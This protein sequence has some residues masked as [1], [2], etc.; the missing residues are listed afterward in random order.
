MTE[1]NCKHDQWLDELIK[2]YELLKKELKTK[3]KILNKV[4]YKI[5]FNAYSFL[6]TATN[7]ATSWEM[8][9]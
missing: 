2:E 3:Q 8:R 6:D 4:S 7:A 9:Y 1:T 5:V